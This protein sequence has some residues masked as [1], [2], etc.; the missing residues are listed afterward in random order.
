MRKILYFLFIA[1]LGFSFTVPKA[2]AA[3][4][5]DPSIL[6]S[7]A[8]F[9]NSGSMSSGDIQAFLERNGSWLA[10][11]VIP[12]YVTTPYFC[13][14]G[15]GNNITQTV[16][17]RQWHVGGF[18]VY[19]MRA[20][21][22]IAER[23]RAIG[24][25]PQ[26][27]LVLIQRESS[28]ITRSSPSSDF[29][30]AW[31]IFYN[32]DETMTSYGYSCANA[33]EIASNYGGLGLQIS[34]GTF[35]LKNKYNQSSNWQTPI[36]IDG[37]TFTPQSRATK[38]LYIYTPHIYTGNYNFWNKFNEWFGSTAPPAYSPPLA[39]SSVGAVYVID[40][41]KKF[42]VTG[43]AF[44]GWDF[45]W[46]NV[47]NLTFEQEALPTGPTFTHLSLASDGTVYLMDR[48]KKRMITSPQAFERAGLNWG[49]LSSIPGSILDRVPYG[50]P[51]HE[52]VMPTNGDGTVYIATEGALFPISGTAFNDSWRY[53]FSHVGKVPGYV[54][55]NL[56]L[57]PVYTRLALA[58]R[59][60][61][62]VF[63]VDRGIGY[64]VSGPVAAAWKI[65]FSQVR[66][67]NAVLLDEK[68]A[69][70][71][72][73]TLVKQEGG[74][75]TV[76]LVQNGQKLPVSASAWRARRYNFTQ[77]QSMSASLLS[78]LPTG[79]VLK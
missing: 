64:K 54:T 53:S 33:S 1:V 2:E 63:M 48:G 4:G 6:I 15:N 76:F 51:M 77:V 58:T 29:T 16:Q 10:G 71:L 39:K 70:G 25:N 7:D 62:T 40:E 57:G 43:R 67:I 5:F 36:T 22:V 78:T 31:P 17:A 55:A 74:D 37:T 12:E 19:G 47:G 69:G 9:L 23:A 46:V 3:P 35:N 68:G 66:T 49:D 45:S 75:G 50:L 21:D 20:S 18:S 11:Y 52:L 56:R 26:V 38:V 61:G 24:I 42:P 60:D 44:A 28:G 27:L 34:Y 8:Q 59:G 14:D 41:G 79:G 32:F 30:R 73:G 72:L 65:D 13:R